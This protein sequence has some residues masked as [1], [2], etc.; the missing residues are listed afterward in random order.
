MRT[1]SKTGSID[2]EVNTP[3]TKKKGPGSV[4]RGGGVDD[5]NEDAKSNASSS[6]SN[7]AQ[8]RRTPAQVKAADAKKAKAIKS[9][10]DA[11]LNPP[12]NTQNKKPSVVSTNKP[13]CN[14]TKEAKSPKDE[15]VPETKDV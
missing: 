1:R 2:E 4:G 6:S 14:V 10:K 12:A 5:P 3:D 7:K 15:N 13:N 8:V 11:S 9:P